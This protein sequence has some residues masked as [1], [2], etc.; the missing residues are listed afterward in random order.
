MA[1]TISPIHK[2]PYL[3]K[4]QI[5]KSWFVIDAADKTLG[6]LS[7]FVVTRLRG[8]HKPQFTPNQDCGD[9]IIII[10]ASKIKVT[11]NKAKQ[12]MYYQHSRY[13][14]GMTVTSYSEM[15][16]KDPTK[17]LYKAIRG[18]LPKSK[19]AD[20][21]LTNVR[22]FPGAEHTLQ[23]QKPAILEYK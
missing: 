10:N 15:M 6:R 17:V 7:A 4:E 23:A 13:P 14:G 8:K 22:I 18:M 9:N 1:T 12:K 3:K 20:K 11:G 19:L 5:E 2:T 21:I 16:A